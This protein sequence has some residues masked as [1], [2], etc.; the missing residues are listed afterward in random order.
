MTCTNIGDESQP[1]GDWRWNGMQGQSF[2]ESKLSV[3][4]LKF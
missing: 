4:V 3:Y 1:V 2:C